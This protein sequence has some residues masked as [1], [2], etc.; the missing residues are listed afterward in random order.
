MDA[1]NVIKQGPDTEVGALLPASKYQGVVSSFLR[2]IITTYMLFQSGLRQ[3]KP[4][5]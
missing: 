1:I 3:P 4:S 2:V 5:T